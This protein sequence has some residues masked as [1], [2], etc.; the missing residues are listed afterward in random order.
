MSFQGNWQV[1]TPPVTD[2]G[3][4]ARSWRLIRGCVRLVARHSAL[5]VVAAWT[6]LAGVASVAV[7]FWLVD[8]LLG[9][10]SFRLE[11][12]VG[13]AVVAWPATIISTLGGVLTCLLATDAIEGRE[14]SLARAWA[15]ARSRWRQILAWA[16]VAA[17]VGRL[18]DAAEQHLPCGGVLVALVADVAWALATLFAVPVLALEG[19]RPRAVVQRSAEIFR[20]RWGTALRGTITVGAATAV[21]TVPAVICLLAGFARGDAVLVVLGAAVLAVGAWLS[22]LVTQLFQLAVYRDVVSDGTASLG[23]FLRSDLEQGMDTR[24]RRRFGR[25]D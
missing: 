8:L 3:R 14:P 2:Q 15:Q 11:L 18:L 19:G 1:N 25:R 16:F 7:V 9:D 20:L 5:R 21:I 22:T 12:L 10:A 17:L 4:W 13:G 24:G 23:P 6:L